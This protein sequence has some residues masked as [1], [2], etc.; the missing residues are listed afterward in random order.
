LRVGNVL[1]KTQFF[2]VLLKNAPPHKPADAITLPC[3]LNLNTGRLHGLAVNW[4]AF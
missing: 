2:F 4:T 3:L 1:K